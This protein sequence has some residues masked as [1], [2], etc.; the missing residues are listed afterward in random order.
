MKN[1]FPLNED[2]ERIN[3]YGTNRSCTRGQNNSMYCFSHVGNYVP[4]SAS[5][6]QTQQEELCQKENE[7]HR[8]V[9]RESDDRSSITEIREE[10]NP[11]SYPVRNN[12]S[13]QK[14]L[15]AIRPL[16][17]GATMYKKFSTNILLQQK[18]FDPLNER[19][20]SPDM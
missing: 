11:R 17:S 13:E 10:S 1:S 12:K 7:P 14:I 19:D 15:E 5:V 9:K 6:R 2:V 8:S 18:V 4:L 3:A 16:I 20:I